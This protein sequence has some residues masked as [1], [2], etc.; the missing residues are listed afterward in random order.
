VGTQADYA[1]WNLEADECCLIHDA[2]GDMDA[3]LSA[4]AT[5]PDNDGSD[6]DEVDAPMWG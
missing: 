2:I 5:V 6:E 4:A 1:G 3:H